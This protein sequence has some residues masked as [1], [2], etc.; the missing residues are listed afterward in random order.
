MTISKKVLGKYI[1]NARVFIETGTHIGTTTQIAVDLGFE[2]IYTI[3]LAD[4]FYQDAKRKFAKYPQVECIFGD[5]SKELVSILN[6][7]NESAVFWLDGHWSGGDT[8]SGESPVPLFEELAIIESHHIKTHTILI[9][10]IRLMGNP[11]EER[12][13]ELS[14]KETNERCKRIN[15]EYKFMF[16]DGFIKNDI[17]VAFI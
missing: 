6:E 4:H 10:D 2:K 12:W 14:I 8:A 1:N 7:L 17:L 5:S 16:E 11:N 3:E 15:P 13:N 9:D